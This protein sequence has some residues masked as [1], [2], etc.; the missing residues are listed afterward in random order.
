MES[1]DHMDQALV[2]GRSFDAIPCAS[3]VLGHALLDS[4][5]QD[6]MLDVGALEPI[7]PHFLFGMSGQVVPPVDHQLPYSLKIAHIGSSPDF[8][9]AALP[10]RNPIVAY[11]GAW[12]QTG[13]QR[14]VRAQRQDLLLAISL[15]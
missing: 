1:A 4:P 12:C 11:K 6:A 10:C 7:S 2:S 13:F 15:A 3:Y 5:C 8:G 9:C 14:V